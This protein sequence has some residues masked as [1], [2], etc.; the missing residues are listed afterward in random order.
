MSGNESFYDPEKNYQDFDF[1]HQSTRGFVDEFA[2]GAVV[3]DG[4]DEAIV[5]FA[6]RINLD[7]VVV[8]SY[9]LLVEVFVK[10]GM[11]QDEA[12]EWID[13]NVAGSW[14]GERTPVILYTP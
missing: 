14:V 4:C 13:F 5:G 10:Q 8:Y 1:G 3:F 6:T 12:I 2:E 11:T 7:P 9:N